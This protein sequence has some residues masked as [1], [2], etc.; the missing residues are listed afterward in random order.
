MRCRWCST[1]MRTTW[2]VYHDSW[3]RPYKLYHCPRCKTYEKVYL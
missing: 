1:W 2:V 3:G